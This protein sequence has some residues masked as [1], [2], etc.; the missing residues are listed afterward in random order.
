M[1]TYLKEIPHPQ[2]HLILNLKLHLWLFGKGFKTYSRYENR[3][4]QMIM[5]LKFKKANNFSCLFLNK[6]TFLIMF[7]VEETNVIMKIKTLQDRDTNLS[8]KPF[9]KFLL[10]RMRPSVESR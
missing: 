7:R 1:T 2:L 3:K 10:F 8:L 4:S 9:M 5:V 6:K